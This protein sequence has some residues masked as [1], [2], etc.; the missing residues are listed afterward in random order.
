M[1][2]DVV[3]QLSQTTGKGQ[4]LGVREPFPCSSLT[5]LTSDHCEIWANFKHVSSATGPQI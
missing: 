3:H 5:M 2:P 4:A 1:D